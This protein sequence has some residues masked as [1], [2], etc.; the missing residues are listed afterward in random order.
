MFVIWIVLVG[1]S[2]VGTSFV[3][4]HA[5]RAPLNLVLEG[6]APALLAIAA[7][8]GVGVKLGIDLG[9]RY[10]T[11]ASVIAGVLCT[12]PLFIAYGVIFGVLGI[13]ATLVPYVEIVILKN[14]VAQG[15]C[16]E[17]IFRGF[18]FARLRRG[19]SFKHAATLSAVAFAVAHLA[20]F[21][22]G[23][24]AAVIMSVIASTVF[25]FLLA[26]PSALFR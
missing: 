26:Y 15:I 5:V 11:R 1:A 20:N 25:A 3:A 16:E 6:I 7:T 4:S 13:E 18:V 23:L 9:L 19:R 2:Q 12:L 22:H 21:V 8:V 14:I 24:S 17:L 10:A